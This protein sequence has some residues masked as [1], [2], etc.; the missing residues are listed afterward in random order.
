MVILVQL[1]TLHSMGK[2]QLVEEVISML[3]YSVVVCNLC[4]HNH[5]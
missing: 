4:T 2:L 3:S 1:I 5:L